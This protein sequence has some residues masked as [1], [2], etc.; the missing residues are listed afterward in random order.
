MSQRSYDFEDVRAFHVKFGLP[1]DAPGAAVEKLKGDAYDFRVGFMREELKEYCDARAAG[2][3]VLAVDALLDFIYVAFGTALFMRAGAESLP[4]GA[5]W[6]SFDRTRAAAEKMGALTGGKNP[7]L[8]FDEEHAMVRKRIET[9][10]ELFELVSCADFLSP[11]LALTH[12]WNAAWAAYFGAAMMSVPWPECWRHVQA[13][14]LAKARAA[15]DGSDSKRSSAWDVVKP[16][17]WVSPNAAI[18]KEL[19]IAGANIPAVLGLR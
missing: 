4:L 1:A 9:E 11:A 15:A 12:L 10:L 7:R 18:A 3:L 19:V 2:D 5:A 16:A 13:A 8:P 17:G 6:P 14:N